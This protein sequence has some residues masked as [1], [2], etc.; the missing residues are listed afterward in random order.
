[1]RDAIGV[2]ELVFFRV[3]T[4]SWQAVIL[5]GLILVAQRLLRDRISPGWRHGLW[6][7]LL[8]RLLL[9]WPV[10]V[11]ISVY[12][13]P[14]RAFDLAA[15]REERYLPESN[16][17]LSPLVVSPDAPENAATSPDATPVEVPL[18]VGGEPLAAGV[19]RLPVHTPWRFAVVVWVLGVA[20][21][22][23]VTVANGVRLS[24]GVSKR[25]Q[26]TDPAVLELLEDCKDEL[27]V[28]TWLE[29]VV[30]PCVASP[31]LLGML[32]PRLLFPVSLIESAS[33]E[34]LRYVCLHE[35]AHLKR[36]DI[37]TGWLAN[38]LVAVHWFNPLMWWVRKR[39]AT[40]RELACDAQ[41][42]SVLD[43]IDRTN[44]G[45]ALLD[46]FQKF[47]PPRW[48]PGLAGVL[49]NKTNMERRIAMV[50]QYGAPTKRG[51]AQALAAA[52]L[53]GAFLLI[54]AQ[55]PGVD[56]S[57]SES[58]IT[59]FVMDNGGTMIA[60]TISNSGP[61]DEV[62]E[63]A[64][65]EGDPGAGGRRINQGGLLVPSGK[66]ATEA[67]SWPVKPGTYTVYAVV[68]PDGKVVETNE[69][70]NKAKREIRYEEGKRFEAQKSTGQTGA[71]M[72]SAL[73]GPPDVAASA[74]PGKAF[75]AFGVVF[76]IYADENEMHFCPPLSRRKGQLTIDREH[77]TFNEFIG[78]DETRKELG[79]DRLMDPKECVYL[80]YMLMD[81]AAVAEFAQAYAGR[82]EQGNFET[83][84]ETPSGT[85]I[86][87]L[88]EGVERFLITD[89]ND[90]GQS[91]YHQS[92]IPILF[93]W[94]DRHEPKGGYVLY[95]DGHVEYLAYPGRF[96]MTEQTV[97]TLRNLAGLP[98]IPS[99]GSL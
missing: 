91:A 6:G 97:N 72:S 83:N 94:P 27:R 41:V 52:A 69:A 44:Y 15:T 64:F 25:R 47:S 11:G 79:T 70:N 10:P 99:S 14:Q 4:I 8:V 36:G 18:Q 61:R 1:M 49:E 7:L 90:P 23:S 59:A 60:A 68:D 74:D 75:K 80:G 16:P 56:L 71:A 30:T 88:R 93:E 28:R 85:I 48:S 86:Q 67:V 53:L 5:I 63:V 43:P 78:S 19:D 96:P 62:V 2:L 34:H 31:A 66:V 76:K 32:R 84:L 95:M 77:T 35:L 24:R 73:E 55:E 98:S 20:S 89:I 22:I 81:D 50:T 38:V 12:G 87:R 57:I 33:R 37:V 21:V 65:Y 51:K 13:L 46:Q 39:I 29:I 3:L 9:L 58:D 42:L 45:H 82:I 40:D 92:R 26:V 54:D 17:A